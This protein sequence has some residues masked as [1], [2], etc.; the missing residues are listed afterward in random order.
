V[1][2][3]LADANG[4]AGREQQRAERADERATIHLAALLLR[5]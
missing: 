3:E 5:S 4:G 1:R 2:R